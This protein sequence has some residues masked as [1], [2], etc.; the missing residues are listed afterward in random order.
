M[1]A[2]YTTWL[3]SSIACAACGTTVPTTRA[4][5]GRASSDHTELATGANDGSARRI[6]FENG[7]G[8]LDVAVLAVPGAIGRRLAGIVLLHDIGGRAADLLTEGRAFAAAGAVALLPDWAAGSDGW[9][10]DE[11]EL[12][13]RATANVQRSFDALIARGDVDPERLAFVGV[14]FGASVGAIMA[15]TDARIRALILIE[16]PGDS[17]SRSRA[18]RERLHQSKTHAPILIQ[19]GVVERDSGDDVSVWEKVVA[20]S[21]R[22]RW[23]ESAR[24]SD[25]AAAREAFLASHL[26]LAIVRGR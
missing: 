11:A 12:L 22:I 13:Q 15:T 24:A 4:D 3:A 5:A 23:Y 6:E 2:R 14:G 20:S 1:T 18:P 17:P 7:H 9:P 21:D 25:A 26:D 19:F 8:R 16:P 10:S